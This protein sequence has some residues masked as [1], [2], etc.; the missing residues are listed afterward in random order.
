MFVFQFCLEYF[1]IKWLDKEV[2]DDLR[3]VVTARDIVS[4]KDVSL[5]DIEVNHECE[6][7]YEG[8]LYKALVLAICI[9]Y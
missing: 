3:D 5:V 1:L 7:L 2:T 4:P 8:R 9:T 6:V